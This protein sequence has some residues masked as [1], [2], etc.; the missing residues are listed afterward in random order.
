MAGFST[1]LAQAILNH[2]LRGVAYTPPAGTYLAL[3]VADITDNNVTSNEVTGAWYARQQ[4]TSWAAPVGSGV[5]TS[6][7][8]ALAYSAITDSA[9]TVTHWGLYDAATSGNLLASGEFVESKVG[10]VNNRFKIAAGEVSLTFDGIFSVHLAQS[11]INFILRGQ[12]FTPPSRYLALYTADPTA[13]DITANEISAAWYARQAL[14]SWDAP[15]GTGNSTA[16]SNAFAFPDTTVATVVGTYGGIKDAV[17]T[18]NLLYS[19]AL[20][21]NETLNVGDAFAGQ[22]GDI[23]VALE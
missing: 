10:N 9:V 20:D 23:T 12:S 6:N 21:S 2:S 5:S 1:Y 19:G 11:L 16:N 14:S 22:A 4:I 15:T 8:N 7:S 17:T 18:G 3:A 13:S